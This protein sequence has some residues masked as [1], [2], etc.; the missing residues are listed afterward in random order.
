VRDEV[1][2]DMSGL[3]LGRRENPAIAYSRQAAATKATIRPAIAP[4]PWAAELSLFLDSV[5]EADPVLDELSPSPLET[6]VPVDKGLTQEEVSEVVVPF[7]WKIPPR[8]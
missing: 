5:G 4:L 3:T 2:K 7:S 6:E 8:G 1:K